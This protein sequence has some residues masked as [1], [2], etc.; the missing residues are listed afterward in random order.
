MARQILVVRTP[1][2]K[3][4]SGDVF[5]VPPPSTDHTVTST[6]TAV[7]FPLPLR[8][9]YKEDVRLR[10]SLHP[11]M[12]D[13]GL[14]LTGAVWDGKSVKAI[15]M[16]VGSAAITVES[17]KPTLVAEFYEPIKFRQVGEQIRGVDV[18][19][20]SSRVPKIEPKKQKKRRKD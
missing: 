19:K 12:F 17:T 15:F 3:E 6:P 16:A 14:L 1:S 11:E 13:S 2:V 7:V 18:V 4:L 20:S 8:S 5:N 9:L 10:F